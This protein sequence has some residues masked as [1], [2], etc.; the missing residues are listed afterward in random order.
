MTN[1][2]GLYR[3]LVTFLY[4]FPHKYYSLDNEPKYVPRNLDEIKL[5]SHT[6]LG[7]N[8][9]Y[10]IY[11][12]N[13]VG[14]DTYNITIITSTNIP[15]NS[16]FTVPLLIIKSKVN[17]QGGE[18]TNA[19][20]CSDYNITRQLFTPNHLPNITRKE[21]IHEPASTIP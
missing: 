16:T 13:R 11:K 7:A 19:P 20:K 5:T 3:V 1:T 4:P 10:L 21:K 17:S 18:E 6:Q 12:G 2:P 9:Q 15:R 8:L 14:T